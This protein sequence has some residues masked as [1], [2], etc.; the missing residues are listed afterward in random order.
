MRT[1]QAYVVGA[2]LLNAVAVRSQVKEKL[3][4]CILIGTTLASV[5]ITV[6][7]HE[8]HRNDNYNL[9][10]SKRSKSGPVISYDSVGQVARTVRTAVVSSK[11]PCLTPLDI[12]FTIGN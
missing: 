5:M 1:R 12:V 9:M 3:A 6:L 2:K 4:A 11:G 7:P 10:T 8:L